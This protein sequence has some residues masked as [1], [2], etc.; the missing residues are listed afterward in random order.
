MDIL[1]SLGYIAGFCT[2]LAFLPQV[3]R[4]YKTRHARDI[5]YGM[6]LLLTTGVSLWF[7]YGL[8]IGELPITLANG[9]TLVLLLIL[10]GMKA[11]FP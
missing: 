4:T 5:S 1:H 3:L 10:T 8:V 7:V 2:T 6:L 11:S 9:I